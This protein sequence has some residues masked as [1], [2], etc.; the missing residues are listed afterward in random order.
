MKQGRRISCFP[1]SECF[2]G[3]HDAVDD[4]DLAD[5]DVLGVVVGVCRDQAVGVSV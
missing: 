4:G 3:A 1:G 5:W 2:H